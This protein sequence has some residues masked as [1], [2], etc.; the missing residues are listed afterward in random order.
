M[1]WI[2]MLSLLFVLTVEAKL[3]LKEMKKEKRVAFVIVNDSY[4]GVP[5]NWNIY[6]KNNMNEFL[7]EKGFK[8][9]YLRNATRAEMIKS[10]RKFRD[11]L[12]KDTIA[13]FY[14]S[15]HTVEVKGVNYLL[16]MN[17][18][19]DFRDAS[20]MKIKLSAIL[21]VMARFSSRKNMV[22]I[23]TIDNATLRQKLKAKPISHTK[24]PTSVNTD[25]VITRTP[26][27]INSYMTKKFS[28]KGLSNKVGF[29]EMK[30][31]DK[32]VYI[33]LS[34]NTFY[35][36]VPSSLKSVKP[37]PTAEDVLWTKMVVVNNMKSYETYLVYFPNGKY[38]VKAQKNMNEFQRKQDIE[39]KIA[40]AL[41]EK[42]LQE[43]IKIEQQKKVLAQKL[44]AKKKSLTYLEP[45]MVKIEPGHYKMGCSTC[46]NHN[47]RPL[48]YVSIKD[49]F[50]IGK[51]EITN[52]EYNR[53]LLFM[54]KE[55]IKADKKLPVIHISWNEAMAYSVWL[56]EKTGKEYTLPSESQWE[57]VSRANTKTKYSWGNQGSKS[58]SYAWE[59]NNS[60]AVLHKVG[61]KEPNQWGVYDF[62][63]NA[64]EWCKDD[65]RL[66]YTKKSVHSNKKVVRGGSFLSNSKDLRA[67]YRFMK[68]ANTQSKEIGFRLILK[69]N[70]TL[71]STN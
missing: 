54:K 32:K 28:S 22:L 58:L 9:I 14:Y 45:K 47:E 40:L 18:L 34:K 44:A 57:Y 43:S 59:K 12:T 25:L 56:S 33:K 17:T 63:G 24:I 46:S 53:Y 5:K 3:S 13:L 65:Y 62:S 68:V 6:K 42:K 15:G 38:K 55:K 2:V 29:T 21:N 37:K 61:Q 27:A 51:Y 60:E 19:N 30:G 69:E 23:D 31:V 20:K 10:M 41:E 48:H 49:T 26:N 1:R 4:Q 16:P 7:K 50:Y 71:L 35:F 36:D 8:T 39:T 67:S 64:S 52:E 11:A 66:D 70:K